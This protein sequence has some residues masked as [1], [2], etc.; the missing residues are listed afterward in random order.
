MAV[1]QK[2][3]ILFISQEFSP[4]IEEH[5]FAKILNELAVKSN[6]SGYEVRI[7]MP[8]FGSI[9]ERRHRLHEVVRLSGI[10]INVDKQ[11]YPLVI[12]V[13]SLPNA[14]LQVY[15]MDNEDM[16]KRK[17]TFH[18]ENGDFYEDNAA[19]TIFFC[20]GA[21]ETVK[22]FGWPPDVIHVHGWMSGLIPMYI[23]AYYKKEPV[24]ANSKLVFSATKESMKENLGKLFGKQLLISTPLKEKDVEVYKSGSNLDMLMGGAMN[25]DAVIFADDHISAN[26][27]NSIKPTRSKKVLN[28]TSGTDD[29]SSIIELYNNLAG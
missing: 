5:E 12:K 28:F 11:D 21:L 27:L 18:E 8:R 24:F 7:I 20:K 25:A 6:E 19:R 3:K 17:N 16:Y 14:R 29:I 4:Y 2:K 9:N 15:F 26:L 22:K 23:K 13:A 1:I 10:N